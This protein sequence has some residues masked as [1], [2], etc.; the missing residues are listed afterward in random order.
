M[1][2]FVGFILTISK[3]IVKLTQQITELNVN[4]KNFS[5][6]LKEYKEKSSKTHERIFNAIEEHDEAIAYHELR[7]HGLENQK[8]GNGCSCIGRIQERVNQRK[9]SGK[10]YAR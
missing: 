8:G 3:P 4:V 6:E 9:D 1:I 10:E 2:T 5:E 7:L